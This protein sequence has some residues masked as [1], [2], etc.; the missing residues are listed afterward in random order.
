[1]Q[2]CIYLHAR[3]RETG[4]WADVDKPMFLVLWKNNNACELFVV[5]SLT[6]SLSDLDLSTNA[7]NSTIFNGC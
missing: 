2:I 3:I 4:S 6:V 7:I 1:M 5:V